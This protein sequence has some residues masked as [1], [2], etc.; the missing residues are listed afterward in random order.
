MVNLQSIKL[1]DEGSKGAQT[2]NQAKA[3]WKKILQ[4]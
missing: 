4:K 1:V 2:P 3:G